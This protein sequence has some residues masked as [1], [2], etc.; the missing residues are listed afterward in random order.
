MAVYIDRETT[1]EALREAIRAYPLSFYN[2]IEVAITAVF[3]RPAT[4]VVPRDCYNLL[5]AENDDLKEQYTK[6]LKAA[7]AMH[8]WIFLNPVD[9]QAAYMECGLDDDMNTLLGY[10]GSFEIIGGNNG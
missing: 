5:L 3:K 4:D 6:V 8:T 7:R 1:I 2:G 9:E 10:G